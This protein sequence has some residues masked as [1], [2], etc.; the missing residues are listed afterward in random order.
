MNGSER[1]FEFGH[2]NS[3]FHPSVV[4]AIGGRLPYFATW[5]LS[6]ADDVNG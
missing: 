1:L 3:F 6:N 2:A 5:R 4:R